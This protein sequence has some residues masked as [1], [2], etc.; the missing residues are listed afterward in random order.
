MVSGSSAEEGKA[1]VGHQNREEKDVVSLTRPLGHQGRATAEEDVVSP[2]EPP[3]HQGRQQ[4]E[5]DVASPTEP[6][7]HQ[8]REQAEEDEDM[9]GLGGG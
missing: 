9:R 2:T 1:P 4:A 3:G 6:L 7:G 8:G 5:E